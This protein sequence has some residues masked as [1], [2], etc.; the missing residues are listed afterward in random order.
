[1]SR[2]LD[3]FVVYLSRLYYRSITKT[4]ENCPVPDNVREHCDVP[5]LNRSGKQLLMDIFE[6]VD[7]N[8]ERPVIIYIHGGGLVVGDKIMSKGF[9]IELAKR[10]FLVFALNYQLA[11]IVSVYDQFDDV[12]AGMDY[13]GSRIIDFDVNPFRIYLVADSAGAYLSIYTA[14]MAKSAKIQQALGQTPTRMS[15]KAMALVGGMFYTRNNDAVG[16][17]LSHF[18][19]RDAQKNKAMEPYL[20]PGNA[21]VS[22]NLPP[23]LLVTSEHD[24]LRKYSEKLLGILWKHNIDYHFVYMGD[25]KRFTHVYPVLHPE[26]PESQKVIDIIKEW[27]D[28]Y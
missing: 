23:C 7:D 16:K 21:E 12:S 28:K 22:G 20:D 19:Y 26:D 27:F 8:R 4:A 3:K 6:P 24:I 17:Y 9:C 11:P 14:A 2:L 18:F 10:G 1:M 25:D 15:Y 5:Y 13:V